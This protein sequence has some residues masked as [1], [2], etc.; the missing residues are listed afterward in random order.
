MNRSSA[1]ITD[2][3]QI[4]SQRD[5]VQISSALTHK[6]KSY[7]NCHIHLQEDRGSLPISS[8]APAQ[9]FTLDHNCRQLDPVKRLDP[10][11]KQSG[12]RELQKWTQP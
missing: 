3:K 2:T 7:L 6:K 1:T 8:S 5:Q 9:K 12:N 11:H 10:T 4:R